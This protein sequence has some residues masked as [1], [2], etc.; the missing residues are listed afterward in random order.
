MH[1]AVRE[2]YGPTDLSSLPMFAGGFINFGHWQAVDLTGPIGEAERIRS[3]QDLYRRVLDAAG[4]AAAPDAG[5]PDAAAR[6]GAAPPKDARVLEVGCGLGMGCALALREY[7]PASVTGLD[8]HPA[9]L[10]RA[11]AAHAGL[12]TEQPE[13]L[14]FAQGAAE[15]IPFPDGEFDILLSVEA[16][17]HFPDLTAFAAEAARVLRP[18]GRVAVAGFFTADDSPERPAQLASLLHTFE[19]GLDLAR[20]VTALTEALTTAGCTEVRTESLGPHVWPGWDTWLSRWWAPDTWPRN[21]LN[22]Y[23]RGI[24]DYYLV[25]ATRP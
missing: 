22:A 2:T 23:R 24:L 7:G 3:Q 13:R 21:F 10:A 5:G 25:T 19:T 1:E 11:R 12:L 18:G 9:Q 15:Q 20:P 6:E 4:L 16:A 14:R 17:Q 8:V